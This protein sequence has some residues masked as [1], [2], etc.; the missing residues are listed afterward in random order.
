MTPTRRL[1]FASGL[2]LLPA[3]LAVWYP[4]WAYLWM[5]GAVLLLFLAALDLWWVRQIP[6]PRVERLL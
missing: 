5:A 6:R 1:I 4:Y 3:L 2:L